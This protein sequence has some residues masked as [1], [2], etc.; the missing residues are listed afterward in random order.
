MRKR[1]ALTLHLDQRTATRIDRVALRAGLSRTRWI[2]LGLQVL[3]EAA[4]IRQGIGPWS[5][6]PV[7]ADLIDFLDLRHGPIVTTASRRGVKCR[8]GKKGER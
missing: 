5:N 1:M 3:S 8:R 7:L 4:D 6:V 2:E